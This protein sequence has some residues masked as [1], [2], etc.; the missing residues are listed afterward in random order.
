MPKPDTPADDDVQ[1]DPKEQP[2]IPPT[3][4]QVHAVSRLEVETEDEGN[5]DDSDPENDGDGADSGD[6]GAGD[7]DS[8]DDGASDDG[9]P[10]D[11]ADDD[12]DTGDGDDGDGQTPAPVTPEPVK[13]EPTPELNLDINKDAPGKVSIRDSEGNTLYF[14]N[15]D[16]V[17]DSF[18]PLSYKEMMKG[19]TR[20]AD[21]AAS[22]AKNISDAQEAAEAEERATATKALEISWETD[23][24]ALTDSG[25]LPKGEKNEEAKEEVYDYIESEMGKGN[26]ITSF[27]QAYKSMM[28]DKQEADKVSRQKK[29]DD[30]KK[31]RSD[32]I[33]GGSGGGEIQKGQRGNKIIEAPPQGAGLDAVHARAINSL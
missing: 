28:Y 30:T 11:G 32:L 26:I 20:L 3:L 19:V 1:D 12:A 6:P 7:D 33:Q 22:D 29:I 27:K 9:D 10:G 8:G 18:E 5:E 2:G 31:K 13:T 25:L 23:A 4:D 14:N 17:P 21:K 15:L 24:K 16:E